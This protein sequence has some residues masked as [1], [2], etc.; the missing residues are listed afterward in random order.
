MRFG[1]VIFPASNCDRDCV[2]VLRAVLGQEVE[3]GWYE[4]RSLD[5]LDAVVLAG[6]FA[7]GDY[8]RAGA[9]AARAPGM[10][11]GR[12]FAAWGGAVL[13]IR[14]GFW[15]WRDGRPV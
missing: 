7:Y 2:H 14:H 15:S 6:G 1:V 10:T 11:A 3:E 9:V 8:L 4:E 13:A 12:A 5:G